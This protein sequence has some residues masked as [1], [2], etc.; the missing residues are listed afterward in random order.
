[1]AF[2]T[3]TA[4]SGFRHPELIDQHHDIR[5]FTFHGR[6]RLGFLYGELATF[7][8]KEPIKYIALSYEWGDGVPEKVV[9]INHFPFKVR[10]NLYEFLRVVATHHTL[11]TKIFIDAIC[12]NQKDRAE[13]SNQVRL[14]PDIYAKAHEVRAWLGPLPS[15]WYSRPEISDLWKSVEYRQWGNW[16]LYLQATRN[17]TLPLR[18]TMQEITEFVKRSGAD[19]LTTIAARVAMQ[20]YFW[21]RL[22]IVSLSP[23]TLYHASRIYPLIL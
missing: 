3:D 21:Q 9:V 1:M 11:E 20:S 2:P 18:F 12:I 6:N 13:R 7:S 10:K 23:F 19:H 15:W 5:L 22:W 4:N 14:M 17:P 16:G 8:L